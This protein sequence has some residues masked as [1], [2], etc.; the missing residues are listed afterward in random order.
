MSERLPQSVARRVLLKLYLS[1]DHV[2][3]ATGKTLAVVISKNGSAFANPSGGATNATEIGLGWYYVDLSTTDT[4][5]LGPLVVRGTAASCDDSEDRFLVV[6]PHNAGFDALPSVTGGAAGGVPLLDSDLAIG[7]KLKGVLTTLLTETSTGYLAAAF[8]KLFDVA[9]PVLTA[10]S[11]NQTGNAYGDT[12]LLVGRLTSARAGYLDNLNVG[13]NVASHADIAGLN[14][15]TALARLITSPQYL[16]PAA[17]ATLYPITLIVT[18][19]EGTPTD[20]DG[21]GSG[22]GGL[23]TVVTNAAGTDRSSNFS[24]WTHAATGRYEGTY[25]VASG[26]TADP[27][28]IRVTGTVGSQAFIGV[29][30]PLVADAFSIDFS[31]TDRTMLTALYN[32]CPAHTPAVNAAGG[33]TVAGFENGVIT[34]AAFTAGAIN[35]SVAPNLDS[36]VSS[37]LAASAVPANFGALGISPD[38]QIAE[39]IVV[40]AATTLTNAPADSSGTAALLARLTAARAGYLDNLNVGGSVASHADCANVT[41]GAVSAGAIGSAA[42]T[43]SA[44]AGVAGGILEKL[45]Q[46]WRR[47]FRKSTLTATE[48]KTYADDEASVLT[49]QPVSDDGTTQTQGGAS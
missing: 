39:V 9:S 23:T 26:A 46:L 6:D 22:V 10:A 17:S 29:V 38:G 34:S 41:V 44:P 21:S 49:T 2:S 1:S 8:K 16:K 3:V 31:S 33:V 28:V 12:Q 32:V 5:T 13:G 19:L 20:A 24:G 14:N 18:N 25:S 35:S 40:D 47:F 43:V 7:S 30:E 36:A 15:S 37:R 42:F 4:G 45:D 48:L 27:L 11:V